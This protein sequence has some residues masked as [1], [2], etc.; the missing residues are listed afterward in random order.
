MI[1]RTARYRPR[2]SELINTLCDIAHATPELVDLR[3]TKSNSIRRAIIRRD[4]PALYNWLMRTFSYQ[5][6]SDRAVDHYISQ[7]GNA[8]Y[9]EIGDR[10]LQAECDKLKGFW[11]F[12]GCGYEK[13]GHKCSCPS[14]MNSCPLPSLPLRNGRLNQLA[15]SLYFFI[16][17]V[18]GGNLVAYIDQAVCSASDALTSRAMHQALVPPWRSIFG[19]SDKTITMALTTLLMSSPNRVWSDA[20]QR[21]IV[22]DTLVHNFL[23]RT[24]TSP[25]LGAVHPYGPR[26]YAPG[27]C[28]DVIDIL[29]RDV[30]ARRFHMS[31]PAHFPRF[32]QLAIWRYCAQSEFDIC[33]GNQIDDRKRC[34]NRDCFLRHDCSRIVL[35]SA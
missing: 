16:R 27:G 3:G 26:C 9:E 12:N 4:T 34:E 33:N 14:K 8:H 31:F 11:S 2:L 19:V 32:V 17:D 23:Q 20:G 13:L 7:H 28:F 29:A 6:I 18:T 5:G 24:G 25:Y 10:L 35:K 15:F 22:V 30:D 21:L 1:I